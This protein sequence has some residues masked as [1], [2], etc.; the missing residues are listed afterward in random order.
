MRC[1]SCGVENPPGMN[2]CEEC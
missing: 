2:F 1:T